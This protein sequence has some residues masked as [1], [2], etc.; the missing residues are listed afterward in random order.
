MAATESTSLAAPQRLVP[1]TAINALS[2]FRP[3]CPVCGALEELQG[4]ILCVCA[5]AVHVVTASSTAAVRYVY[6]SWC[7]VLCRGF[8]L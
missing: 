2:C 7:F 1:L 5:Y 8:V 3:L 6:F 4:R